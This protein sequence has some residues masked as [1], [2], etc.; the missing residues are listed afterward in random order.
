MCG[1]LDQSTDSLAR[2]FPLQYQAKHRAAEEREKLVLHAFIHSRSLVQTHDGL[3][4]GDTRPGMWQ[5]RRLVQVDS[6]RETS[7][8]GVSRSQ[9]LSWD[10]QPAA[11]IDT[12][13]ATPPATVHNV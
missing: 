3:K 2:R 12:W 7:D 13:V 6:R 4:L 8:R 10:S 9:S 11:D 5:R 1:N